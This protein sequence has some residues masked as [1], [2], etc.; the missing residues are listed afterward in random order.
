VASRRFQHLRYHGKTL[1]KTDEPSRL[2]A[3]EFAWNWSRAGEPAGL[4]A[5]DFLDDRLHR[6]IRIAIDRGVIS[7]GRAKEILR[8]PREEMRRLAADW[9]A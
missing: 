1:C 6:L 7:I 2:D 9:A 5:M 3:S 8:V 4:S